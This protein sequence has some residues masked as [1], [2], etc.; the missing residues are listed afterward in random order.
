MKRRN[1][2]KGM[3]G[4]GLVTAGSC[5][6]R[7]PLIGAA[8]ATPLNSPV[9]V[10]IFQR[11]GCDG[12]NT[13]V[14]YGDPD[15]YALRP[16][17][18]A[19]IGIPAPGQGADFSALALTDHLGLN[20]DLFGLHPSMAPLMPIYNAQNMAVL[21]TVHYP[22][23][24]H[25]HFSSQ[26]YI[27]SGVSRED[28]PGS[29]IDYQNG[30]LNRHL[31]AAGANTPLQAIGYGSK[32]AQA[33][34]GNVPVQ[35]FSSIN[36]FNLGL[37]G[38][39]RQALIDNVGAIYDALPSPQDSYRELVH[40]SGQTLFG[41]LDA[42]SAIDTNSYSVEHGALY[43]NST[44]G[45]SLKETAQMIKHPSIGLEIVTIDVGGYDTHSDQGA[46]EPTGRLSKKLQ[47]FSEGIAALTTDLGERMDDVII[48]TMSEF[49]RTAKANAS[50]GTDHGN[51]A[52]WFVIGNKIQ[53][54]I[55]MRDQDPDG[56]WPGLAETNLYRDRYLASTV[57][58][59]DIFGDILNQHLGHEISEFGTLLPGHSY[60][61]LNLI[62]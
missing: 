4:T 24:S 46:G 52:S 29:D 39:D 25:S 47:E 11:G 51:A 32:L 16:Q 48:L 49:G 56:G 21:P 31:Q 20:N 10:V 45:R 19:G 13:V 5:A 26:R 12:L 44:F 6:F 35:S 18:P 2:I 59:R 34:R 42:I 28:F 17:A 30:W 36:A 7:V 50:E 41:N 8:Q 55:Y 40:Q 61:P 27:E 9:V 60:T 1:F 62:S 15:Y 58:Y 3:L 57:D 23:P 54:G 33:L 43:P 22:S 38:T 14:P 37:S 53:G